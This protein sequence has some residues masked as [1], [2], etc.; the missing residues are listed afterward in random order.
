MSLNTTVK[1]QRNG[2]TLYTGIIV[3]IDDVA[4]ETGAYQQGQT[5]Y[6]SHKIF[7]RWANPDIQHKDLLVD[8]GPGALSYRV[9]GQPRQYKNGLCVV[10]ANEPKTT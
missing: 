6:R 9:N 4:Q 3:Q 7:A 8:E 1:L 10:R 2:T 5:Q